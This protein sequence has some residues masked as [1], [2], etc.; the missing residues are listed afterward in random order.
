MWSLVDV[1]APCLDENLSQPLVPKLPDQPKHSGGRRAQLDQ[2]ESEYD[3]MQL[4][5]PIF[6]PRAASRLLAQQTAALKCAE[7]GAKNLRGNAVQLCERKQNHL[8]CEAYRHL[9][10]F[11][12]IARF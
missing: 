4:V 11:T 7:A 9:R 1:G 8:V 10:T 5:R 6:Q 3:A 12:E 2:L